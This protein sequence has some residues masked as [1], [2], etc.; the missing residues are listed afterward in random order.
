M[1]YLGDFAVSAMVDFKWN[2]NAA[3]GASI[4]RATN[5]TVSVYKDNSTTQ[6]TSGV[7]DT[8]DFDSLT[9]VHH[10]RID[11]SADGTFYAAG[12]EFQVV[13]S[14]AVIDGQ[15]V[16]AVIAHFSIGRA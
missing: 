14:A 12:H 4:T 8:E 1:T 7:T 16:N 5:G 11:L 3:T 9:G 15:T 6:S 13:V 10:C 2:T